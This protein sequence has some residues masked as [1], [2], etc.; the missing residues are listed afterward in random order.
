MH[1]QRA[2]IRYLGII[3][4]RTRLTR[5]LKN[6]DGMIIVH[7]K[8]IEAVGGFIALVCTAAIAMNISS[9][10]PILLESILGK[11]GD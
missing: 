3:I 9:L 6:Q 8:R 2:T 11:A 1:A 4:E 5:K 7:T 10:K